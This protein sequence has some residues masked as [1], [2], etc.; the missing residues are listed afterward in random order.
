MGIDVNIVT[1]LGLSRKGAFLGIP[2]RV[3]FQSSGGNLTPERQM[4][5]SKF[6]GGEKSI[7][8]SRFSNSDSKKESRN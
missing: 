3:V 6:T 8:S 2:S 1:T 4:H 5:G 7:K